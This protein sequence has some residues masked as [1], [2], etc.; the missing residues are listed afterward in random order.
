[1]YVTSACN[2]PLTRWQNIYIGWNRLM[3]QS[4]APM[5]QCYI[6]S[7]PSH[8]CLQTELHYSVTLHACTNIYIVS[9]FTWNFSQNLYDFHFIL[10]N[11]S[12]TLVIWSEKPY[13]KSEIVILRFSWHRIEEWKR[14]WIKIVSKA[15]SY[16]KVWHFKGQSCKK[17]VSRK[18]L[19]VFLSWFVGNNF[20]RLW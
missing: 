11:N 8:T 14:F 9:K 19:K 10:P 7:L 20:C 18:E 6:Y 17:L 1:M 12:V 2:I 5:L 15:Q 16:A 13:T 3:L 4:Y